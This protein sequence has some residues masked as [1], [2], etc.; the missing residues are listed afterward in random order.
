MAK[1]KKSVLIY[2]DWIS[3]FEELSD[4]EAG[5]LVKHLFR[6]VNDKNP[7]AP[8]RLTKLLF[9]PI[10][11]ALK[12]DLVSYK[13]TCEKNRDNA[14]MRWNKLNAN[15][16]ERMPTDAK[17]ADIDNDSDID[18]DKGIDKEEIIKF[19]FKKSLIDLGIEEKIVSE[20]LSVRKKKKGANTETAFNAIKKQI[21]LSGA[22]A[23]D[24]IK[25][26]VE[27]SWCGFEAEWYNN[28]QFKTINNGITEKHTRRDGER[29]N[30][31]WN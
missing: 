25:K 13:T 14:F 1:D 24:C 3:I 22:T 10:K 20:W 21:E 17:H 23:S 6:Y 30:S 15:A 7:E 28:S 8:D 5:K 18:N 4:E 9:E 12:R 29:T 16:C 19:N 31:H 2:V 11:Q 27:K 26:A